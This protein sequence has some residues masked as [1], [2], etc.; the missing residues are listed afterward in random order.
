MAE[1]FALYYPWIN[2][3]SDEWIKLAALYWNRIGRIVPPGYPTRDSPTVEALIADCDLIADLDPERASASIARD[4]LNVL[5]RNHEAL[6]ARYRV[7]AIAHPQGRHNDREP[8]EDIAFIHFFKVPKPLPEQLIR[9]E[10]AIEAFDGDDHWLGVHPR[11][12]EVYM[13]ALAETMASD[14]SGH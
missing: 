12:A 6:R 5:S 10:L 14:E 7:D 1:R 4:F 9:H 13:T 8:S 11:I 3:R 2:I